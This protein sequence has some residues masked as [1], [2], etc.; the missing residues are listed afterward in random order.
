[1]KKLYALAVLGAGL[2]AQKAAAALSMDLPADFAGFSTQDL[3]TT[4]ANIV[5]IVIGFLGIIVVLIILLGGFK[6]ITSGGN[7]DKIGEAKKMI[8]AGV[9][10]LVIVLVAYAITTFVVNS[11]QGAV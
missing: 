9:I 8:S 4:I 10:G 5:R 2:M 7:E 6:W 3:K 1:M 11:L